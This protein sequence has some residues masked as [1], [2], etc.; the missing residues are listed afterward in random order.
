M[1]AEP[2]DH[3]KRPKLDVNN[4][5][6]IDVLSEVVNINNIE[7]I[8]NAAPVHHSVPS[9]LDLCRICAQAQENLIG[10]FSTEG[11][12]RGIES[13]INS[14]LPIKVLESDHLP[15]QVCLPCISSLEAAQQL[16]K[17]SVSSDIILRDQFTQP[18]QYCTAVFISILQAPFAEAQ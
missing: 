13:M 3:A 17:T 2:E 4:E 14:I 9:K 12:T 18:V 6:A 10:I 15:L 11:E 8:C 7:N 16:C 1:A 5:E